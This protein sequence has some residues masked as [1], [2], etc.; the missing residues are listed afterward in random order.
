MNIFRF[1]STTGATLY[2]TGP[3]PDGDKLTVTLSDPSRPAY[4][5]ADLM[6]GSITVKAYQGKDVIVTAS[7]ENVYPDDVEN[8]RLL[9]EALAAD[10]ADALVMESTFGDPAYV[11][12]PREELPAQPRDNPWAMTPLMAVSNLRS[13]RSESQPATSPNRMTNPPST[14]GSM[15]ARL[16]ASFP[17]MLNFSCTK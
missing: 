15:P 6:N 3:T 10:R 13:N 8:R 2:G 5:K 12:A 4:V 7:G 16:A 1:E 11:W 17:G 9:E 14:M